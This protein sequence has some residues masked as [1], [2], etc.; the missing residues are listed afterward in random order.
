MVAVFIY[1]DSSTLINIIDNSGFSA[2]DYSGRGMYGK[3][4]IAVCGNVAEVIAR[5]MYE[6]SLEMDQCELDEFA[7]EIGKCHTDSMGR[8][9]ILYWPQFE[10]PSE[11]AV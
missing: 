11:N 3:E 5:M 2:R 7:E 9:T 10:W 6:A 4:C 8:S 1:M